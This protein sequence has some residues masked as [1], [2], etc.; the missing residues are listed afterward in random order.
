MYDHFLKLFCIFAAVISAH[1][2]DFIKAIA[3]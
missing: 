1:L 2:I 3:L